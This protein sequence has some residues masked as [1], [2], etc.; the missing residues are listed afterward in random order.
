MDFEHLVE[1]NDGQISA[2]I[3]L[4]R[5]QLW[6][7]L[8]IRAERPQLAVTWLDEC[9]ILARGAGYLSRELRFGSLL[10]RDRVTFLPMHSVVYET[11]ASEAMPASRL[12]MLIEEPYPGRLFV[13][14][15]YADLGG[16]RGEPATAPLFSEYLKQAY[17]DVDIDTVV[18]IRRL[19]GEGALDE[20]S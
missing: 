20:A 19:A 10:V 1:I 17:I 14:F 16:P 12:T 18:A 3:P 8:V 9:R 7:G 6:R 5:A 15:T 13:R 2:L 4:T 11:E